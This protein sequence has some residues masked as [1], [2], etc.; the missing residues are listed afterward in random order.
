MTYSI[1]IHAYVQNHPDN[2]NYV[3]VLSGSHIV[4]LLVHTL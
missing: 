4:S 1:E 2:L 3:L